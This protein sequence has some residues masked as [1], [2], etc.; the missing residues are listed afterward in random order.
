MEQPHFSIDNQMYKKTTALKKI[1]ELKKR[2]SIIQG[3]T[4][5]SKTISILI[6]LIDMCCKNTLLEVSVVSESVPHLKKGALKDF[7]KIMKST[8]RFIAANYNATDRKYTFVNGAYM[9]FFSPES[10]LGARRDV[11]FVNECNHISFN[12]FHQLSIRTKQKIYLDY[13]PANEFW[14]QTEIEKDSD[15]EKIILTYKDNEALDENIIKEIEK[16]RD[17]ANESKYWSNWWQVYGLGLQGTI[18]GVVFADGFK[19]VDSFPEY[20]DWICYGGDYG[21]TNDPTTFIKVGKLKG[22]LYFEELIYE[23]GLQNHLIAEKIKSF[24]IGRSEIVFDSSEPKSNDE[25]RSKGLNVF[26]AVKGAD[27][28]NNG[29]NLIKQHKINVVS[30]SLNL[31]KELR[32]YSYKFDKSTNKYLNEPEDN[33]NHCI[34]AIRY[35]V[36]HKLGIQK[37]VGKMV[38]YISPPA[39]KKVF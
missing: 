1:R 21:Y 26:G 13:N 23:T 34:D 8:G 22:E 12:D 32:S 33:N 5:S 6:I 2:V 17:K 24:G 35:S 18:E 38:G 28:I 39:P 20:C 36:S 7:L 31:I 15:A 19:Q 16:A 10:I 14:V 37:P 25:L 9:E 27:S 11:L 3:G 4:S 30:S 29:L